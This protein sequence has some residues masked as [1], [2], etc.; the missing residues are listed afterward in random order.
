MLIKMYDTKCDNNVINKV[1]ENEREFDIKLKDK[2]DIIAP[3]II[4]RSDSL[5][6]S[7]YAYIPEFNR[8]Y[9]VSKIEL[10]PNGIYN[11]SLRCDVLESFKT[12]ILNST[13]FINQQT[14]NVNKYFN[15]DYKSEVRK[16]VDI[17]KS[18]VT[19]P[20]N[21]SETILVTIGGL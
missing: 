9:F 8:Y 11:I 19:I 10:F 20:T 14:K 12:E 18:N 13:G 7:N 17:Y 1:L 6:L 2:T 16:E 5:I 4:L 3:V 15:A 21:V